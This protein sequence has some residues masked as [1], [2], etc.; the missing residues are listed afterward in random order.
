MKKI[1]VVII[2]TL[3]LFNLSAG[4]YAGDF[5]KIG[6]GVRALGMGGAFASVADDCYA[7]FWNPAGIAQLD[8]LQIGLMRAY[9][10]RDLAY[11]D[12]FS[13]CQPLPNSVA[14]G[15][16][17]TR[18]TIE[19]IPVYGE[20]H[21]VGTVDHRAAFPWLNLTGVPDDEFTSTDDLF[22]IAFSKY[23]HYDLN[24]GWNFSEIPLDICLGSNIKYIKRSILDNV[25]TGVGFDLAL[26]LRTSLGVLFDLD[27]LG[28]IALG[29]NFQDLGSTTIVWDTESKH[30]D[31]ILFN[32]KMGISFIQPLNFI[33][34][35]LIL[36]MDTDYVYE[37]VQRF[38]M[39]FQYG[40]HVSCRAGYQ[41]DVISTGASLKLFDIYLD[42]AFINDVLGPTNRVGIR[43]DL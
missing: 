15:I 27:E 42:Y 3:M 24:I 2:F 4:R 43:V 32:T 11:Y 41:E 20:E 38:G 21:L 31:E 19:D 17:W 30:E 13:F 6:S 28:D 36:A 16:N 29:L 37:T 18:L 39:E 23:L 1:I 9:L 7:F 40:E 12:N 5:I 22:Q 10:Y 35:K 14:I 34:S 33:K 26:L 8:D 25:G